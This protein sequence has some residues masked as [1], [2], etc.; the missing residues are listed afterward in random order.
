MV[1]DTQDP[2]TGGQDLPYL[3]EAG[4]TGV[5][6][7][8]VPADEQAEREQAHQLA[9]LYTPDELRSLARQAI[10][11]LDELDESFV[12]WVTNK[13]DLTDRDETGLVGVALSEDAAKATAQGDLNASMND[14]ETVSPLTWNDETHEWASATHG[15]EVTYDVQAVTVRP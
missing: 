2:Q 13:D 14:T 8:R 12:V 3:P 15:D 5:R 7:N 6:E 11:A 9:K 1:Y 10:L 4:G